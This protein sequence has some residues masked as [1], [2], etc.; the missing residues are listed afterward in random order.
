MLTLGDMVTALKQEIEEDE[1]EEG[2]KEEEEGQ[3]MI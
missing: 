3:K 1:E 2:M